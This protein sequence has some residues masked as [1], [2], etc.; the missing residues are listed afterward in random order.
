MGDKD[1]TNG[2]VEE[3]RS[4]AEDERENSMPTTSSSGM[5]LPPTVDDDEKS[6]WSE[7]SERGAKST[8]LFI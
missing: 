7:V 3:S 1:E 2:A 6:D 5:L 8:Y 4:D